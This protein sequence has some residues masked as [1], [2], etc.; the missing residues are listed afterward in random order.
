M[1]RKRVGRRTTASSSGGT[2]SKAPPPEEETTQRW[3]DA[4][5]RAA[6]AA[7]RETGAPAPKL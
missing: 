1:A 7:G 5:E 3:G 6:C 4:R 2:R